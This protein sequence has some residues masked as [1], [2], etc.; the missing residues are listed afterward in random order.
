MIKLSL[1]IVI[2]LKLTGE[3]A[4]KKILFILETIIKH[5]YLNKISIVTNT[6]CFVLMYT[7]S[8]HNIQN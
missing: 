4:M 3:T 6:A 2:M 1:E 7:Y 5:M 8:Y